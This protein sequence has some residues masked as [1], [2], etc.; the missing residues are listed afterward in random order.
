MIQVK[1]GPA[2]TMP[3]LAIAEPGFT[4]DTHVLSIGNGN[5][6]ATRIGPFD[7]SAY[8]TTAHAVATYLTLAGGT[9][10][11]DLALASTKKVT[12]QNGTY[13]GDISMD[14]DG[15]VRIGGNPTGFI[16]GTLYFGVGGAFYGTSLSN[17]ATGSNA[18]VA[19]TATGTTITRNVAD[20]NPALVVNQVHAS[21]TGNLLTLQKS[22][23]AQVWV[24]SGGTMYT[25]DVIPR[26]S[27]NFW[28]GS[29]AAPWAT[30]CGL[31]HKANTISPL[32]GTTTALTGNVS[33]ANNKKLTGG[34]SQP[35]E[36]SGLTIDCTGYGDQ[37]MPALFMGAFDRLMFGDQPGAVV[38]TTVTSSSPPSSGTL[39][40]L[41]DGTP[42][43][44]Q[45]QTPTLPFTL[46]LE[47]STEQSYYRDFTLWFYPG[48]TPK[49][50]TVD[51]YKADGTLSGAQAVVTN[52][53]Q[54]QPS[55]VCQEA[56][57]RYNT[58]KIVVTVT[59]LNHASNLL[60]IVEACW[61]YYSSNPGMFPSYLH[62]GSGGTVYGAVEF[63]ATTT[64]ADINCANIYGVT[65]KGYYFGTGLGIAASTQICSWTGYATIF[66][67]APNGNEWGRIDATGMTAK[68]YKY[69]T[70]PPVYAN[71]AAA[72]AGGLT[73]GKTYRTGGDPDLLCIVH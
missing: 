62:R 2:A 36:V 25:G 51:F 10:T 19:V 15:T 73:A 5:G 29:D 67:D 6:T 34:A 31:V 37:G 48:Y 66:N 4:T 1:R 11:G 70:L 41:I 61:A 23:V 46:T 7:A 14:A 60:A 69:S 22:G 65:H 16:I 71:N 56:R 54:Y 57:S 35:V 26:T 64:F 63:K 68:T 58:K 38:P 43:M 45:W 28:C 30:I 49:D 59:S 53:P 3:E 12:V 27:S 42:N 20:A 47:F 18:S 55:Y 72:I 50:F 13:H 9:L 8:E 33:M 39:S 40:Y 21:S 17:I 24:A 44:T 52:F 32:T